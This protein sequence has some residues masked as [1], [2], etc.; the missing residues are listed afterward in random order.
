MQ[1]V[2]GDSV[3]GGSIYGQYPL[4]QIGGPLDVG[5]GRLIPSLSTHQYSATLSRLFGVPPAQLVD[6]A[7]NLLNF[8]PTN[9][10]FL[11]A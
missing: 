3:F 2:V 10:G 1:L 4:L 8:S 5:G 9:L 11:N 6:I 7:P